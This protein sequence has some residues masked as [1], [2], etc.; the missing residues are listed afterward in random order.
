M[1]AIRIIQVPPGEAP[2]R[3]R[4]AWVGVVIPLADIPLTQPTLMATEGV[5]SAQNGWIVRI[6][7][8]L[9]LLPE[10]QPYP[11]YV[12]EALPA[13]E[14]LAQQAPGAAAWWKRN[15]PDLLVPGACFLFAEWCCEE[16]TSESM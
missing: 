12:V 10:E 3:V 11:G 16:T 4:S 7:R 14:A 15:T 2:L 13:V 9:G 8:R 5:L 1:K 6:K